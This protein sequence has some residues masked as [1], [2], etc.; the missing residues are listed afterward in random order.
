MKK[1]K[2]GKLNKYTLVD[3]EDFGYF[4][5]WKWYFSSR[6]YVT[7]STYNK[8]KVGIIYMSRLIMNVKRGEI[9]DHINGDK[10][11]NRKCNLRFC[12]P[13][14][15]NMNR[16]IQ[17]NN[18]SGYKGVSWNKE[19]NKWQSYFI[20]NNRK[21]HLGYFSD[22]VEAALIYNQTIQQNFKEFARLNI[23]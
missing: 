16:G 8:G 19:K 14:Q 13:Q 15:N 6:G 7:H 10:L 23:F 20:F 3:D 1:I 5:Q 21:K 2:L 17:K 11:D 4:N 12:T 22:K 9:I 18:T